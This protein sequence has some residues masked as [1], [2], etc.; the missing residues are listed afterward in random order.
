M[1]HV[2]GMFGPPRVGLQL[3][4]GEAYGFC[5]RYSTESATVTEPGKNWSPEA[6]GSRCPAPDH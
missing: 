5:Y 1:L 2:L 6:I 3:S 4:G